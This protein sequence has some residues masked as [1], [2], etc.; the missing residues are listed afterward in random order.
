MKEEYYTLAGLTTPESI[1]DYTREALEKE[2][3]SDK[4]TSLDEYTQDMETLSFSDILERCL[5]DLR[6][7]N[8]IH[9][10]NENERL[11]E[12]AYITKNDNARPYFNEIFPDF[13]KQ[14]DKMEYMNMKA[15]IEPFPRG[16]CDTLGA[17]IIRAFA[18]LYRRYVNDGDLFYDGYGLETAGAS[19]AFIVDKL[20]ELRDGGN[21]AEK[22]TKV[23]E[24][25]LDD[26]EYLKALDEINDDLVVFLKDNPYLFTEKNEMDSRN[27]D[28]STLE[29]FEEI[30]PKY[31]VE[32]DLSGD[33]ER[34]IENKCIDYDD[35]EETVENWCEQFG[36]NMG[37]RFSYDTLQFPIENL[38]KE[39]LYTWEH[40]LNS[41]LVLS[42]LDFL[43]EKYPNFGEKE[44][45]DLEENE[46]LDDDDYDR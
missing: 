26:N 30:S 33:I 41:G 2:G 10:I 14:N 38:S 28:S 8:S 35:V 17:E 20:N 16:K 25:G 24:K 1:I 9:E 45:D 15:V 11:E 29:D 23:A 27:W 21:I 22:F 32:I 12:E 46:E 6:S 5:T 34:Y 3:L 36:G 44:E 4:A 7:A 40:E 19:A 18:K 42:H 31:E 43:E 13:E 37:T 39:E